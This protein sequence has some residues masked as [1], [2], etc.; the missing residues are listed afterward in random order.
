MGQGFSISNSKIYI[1]NGQNITHGVNNSSS[2]ETTTP[3]SA[4][5]SS[6]LPKNKSSQ[7]HVTII[8]ISSFKNK[9]RVY[10][11]FETSEV[12][13]LLDCDINEFPGF[14]KSEAEEWYEVRICHQQEKYFESF[15]SS[16]SLS[17]ED[18]VN[19]TTASLTSSVGMGSGSP[20]R[21]NATAVTGGSVVIAEKRFTKSPKWNQQQVKRYS[22]PASKEKN[23]FEIQP[24]SPL[25]LNLS[26]HQNAPTDVGTGAGVAA[27]EMRT[28]TLA[29]GD[30]DKVE[31]IPPIQNIG[32][33]QQTSE[34]FA[35][36]THTVS[37]SLLTPH[38]NDSARLEPNHSD[39]ICPFCK[40]CLNE[41]N[42]SKHVCD[43]ITSHN[44][45]ERFQESDQLLQEVTSF[46]HPP[47][48]PLSL[49]F[50]RKLIKFRTLITLKCT[51]FYLWRWS[52][53][54]WLSRTKGEC[55]SFLRGLTLLP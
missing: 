48:H 32:M 6:S 39:E 11:N 47:P 26:N 22:A 40:E 17:N 15:T 12:L 53:S 31:S 37:S 45:Q 21:S 30:R 9:L 46:P 20:S 36:P 27:N 35:A 16:S 2:R 4:P 10:Q 28:T 43:C 55:S 52:S 29:I 14:T 33:L 51:I 54:R 50:D 5:P 7:N 38:A 8:P 13:V 25:H 3:T 19:G 44:I 49:H 34:I 23:L 42:G 24:L 18:W 41:E 1:D